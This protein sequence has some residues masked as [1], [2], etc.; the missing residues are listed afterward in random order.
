MA[1]RRVKRRGQPGK[2]LAL[3]AVESKGQTNTKPWRQE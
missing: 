1:E 3:T 2:D